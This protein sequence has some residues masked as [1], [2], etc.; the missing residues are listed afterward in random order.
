MDEYAHNHP[1]H[2]CCGVREFARPAPGYECPLCPEHGELAQLGD[3]N[4]PNTIPANVTPRTD[5]EYS[6]CHQLV[7]RPHTDY[8]PT[9]RGIT[10]EMQQL[11]ERMVAD[12][13]A[14]D[15]WR[16]PLTGI[17]V[18]NP[19]GMSVTPTH[20]ANGGDMHPRHECHPDRCGMWATTTSTPPT[21]TSTPDT[22]ARHE[23][24]VRNGRHY[25][26]YGHHPTSGCAAVVCGRDQAES[27][28]TP[29]A[30]PTPPT[31]CE[32]CTAADVG[33]IT[34]LPHTCGQ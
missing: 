28:S 2:C 11:A 14:N 4:P 19:L 6:C 20:H 25:T 8:C 29:L 33:V 24:D 15:P 23:I 10:P 27:G 34:G 21:Q 17:E 3:D 31:D 12:E 9:G 30:T 22:Q 1:P 7:G 18:R 16:A 13:A 32:A 26:R 5:Y